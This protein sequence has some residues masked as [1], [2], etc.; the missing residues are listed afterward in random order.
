MILPSDA[1]MK[2]EV[3]SAGKGCGTRRPG[4]IEGRRPA[5]SDLERKIR[6]GTSWSSL[7]S[8]VGGPCLEEKNGKLQAWR[9]MGE[10][11]PIRHDRNKQKNSRLG[12][13]QKS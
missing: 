7:T 6:E 2:K 5:S 10:L 12:P 1:A 4:K 8:M 3:T 9:A 11:N 13:W